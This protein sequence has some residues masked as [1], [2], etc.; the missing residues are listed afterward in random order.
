M[1]IIIKT[2]LWI[3][4]LLRGVNIQHD[5]P[6]REYNTAT[7]SSFKWETDIGIVHLQGE[8]AKSHQ[9]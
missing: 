4:S 5:K 3:V 2:D 6:D 7:H 1:I 8:P 9:Q